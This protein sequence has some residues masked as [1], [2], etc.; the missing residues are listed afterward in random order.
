MNG[1]GVAVRLSMVL[2]SEI[3]VPFGSTPRD[4]ACLKATPLAASIGELPVEA[5]SFRHRVEGPF[6]RQAM[7]AG[8]PVRPIEFLRTRETPFTGT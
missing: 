7:S 1:P 4:C 8:Q 5:L 6:T 3:I 2:S